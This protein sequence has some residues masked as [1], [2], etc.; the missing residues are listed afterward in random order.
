MNYAEIRNKA[1]ILKNYIDELQQEKDERVIQ[2][3]KFSIN[4]TLNELKEEVF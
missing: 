1:I 2:F 3:L 4:E